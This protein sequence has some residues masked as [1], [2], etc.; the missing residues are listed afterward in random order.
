VSFPCEIGHDYAHCES[1]SALEVFKSGIE[2]V[3]TKLQKDV[4]AI[5]DFSESAG[6]WEAKG[7]VGK[8]ASMDF[9]LFTPF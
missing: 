2:W 1:R 9:I 3:S 8:G 7:R 5:H 4:R 6:R